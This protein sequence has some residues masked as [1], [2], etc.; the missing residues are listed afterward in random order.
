MYNL[1]TDLTKLVLRT[2]FKGQ[3][4]IYDLFFLYDYFPVSMSKFVV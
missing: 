2:N 3:L 4:K 1:K